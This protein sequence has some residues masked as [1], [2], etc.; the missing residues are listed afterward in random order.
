MTT[1]QSIKLLKNSII[2]LFS[3]QNNLDLININVDPMSDISI[4]K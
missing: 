1:D 2:Q 4:K 3:I